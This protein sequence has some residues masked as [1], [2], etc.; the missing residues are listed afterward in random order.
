MQYQLRTLENSIAGIFRPF[1]MN[2]F[3]DRASNG[4]KFNCRHILE[5]IDHLQWIGQIF[6]DFP[7]DDWQV[8]LTGE[9]QIRGAWADFDI[10]LQNLWEWHIDEKRSILEWRILQGLSSI[11]LPKGTLQRNGDRVLVVFA[12]A[13]TIETIDRQLSFFGRSISITNT[14][15]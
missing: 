10:A 7:D 1:E 12:P 6:K 8:Q 2:H 3:C 9:I 11:E 14:L 5:S 4:E 15:G 13:T